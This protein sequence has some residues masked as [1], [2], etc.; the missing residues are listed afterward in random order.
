MRTIL[1]TP[2]PFHE[3]GSE[4]IEKLEQLGYK[5]IVND[6]G[7]RYSKEQLM[8]LVANADA[9]LTG[10]DPLDKELLSQAKNLKV[11]SKY[12]VGLDNIDLTYANE[13]GIKVCKALG[14]NSVSVAESAMM[15]ILTSLRQYNSLCHNSKSGIEKRLMGREAKG[16]TLGILG[17]GAIGKNVAQFA[18]AFEMNIIGYDPYVTQDQVEDYVRMDTFE[19][20]LKQSDVISLHLPLLESTKYIIDELAI[21]KMREGAIV[22]NTARGGLIDSLALFKALQTDKLSFVSEDVELKERPEELKQMERYNIT[23]HAASFTL[24]ADQNT[25]KIAVQNIIDNLEE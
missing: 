25:M 6:T 24:E 20:L 12:G 22:I 21:S 15:M 5:V 18:H 9:I 17:L 23:P 13:K 11:I 10:N 19:E 1:I 8:D 2:R 14:A 16:K 3:K 7:K 4:Q